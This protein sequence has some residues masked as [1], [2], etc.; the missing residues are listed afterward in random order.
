[1]FGG[2]DP[3]VRSNSQRRDELNSASAWQWNPPARTPQDVGLSPACCHVEDFPLN[4]HGVVIVMQG[5][6]LKNRVSRVVRMVASLSMVLTAMAASAHAGACPPPVPEIDPSSVLSAITLLSGG[7]MI[8]TDRR[9]RVA[10]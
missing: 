10:K 9:R 3:E 6:N 2:Y 1:V 7:V 8:L 4:F 5:T